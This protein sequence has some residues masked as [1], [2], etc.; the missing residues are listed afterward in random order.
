VAEFLSD[1]WLAALD[2][3]ARR[4]AAL[5]G[6]GVG[7]P[8]VV[9]QRV[10]RSGSEE[11]V[12]ALCLDGHGARVERGPADAPDVVIVTDLPTA[13]GLLLGTASVQEA[14]ARGRLTIRGRS[15]RLNAV[16]DAVRT[17]D[18]VFREVRDTTTF[19]GDGAPIDPR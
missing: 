13:R 16:S 14:M 8:V 1:E 9:E 4:S 7:A 2:R 19:A 6:V 11:V 17:L 18:D 5:I 12:Y 3:A 15:E 10:R